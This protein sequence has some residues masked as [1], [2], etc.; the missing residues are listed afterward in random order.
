MF[1]E[2]A[3]H[4]PFARRGEEQYKRITT[5]II[6]SFFHEQINIRIE[7]FLDTAQTSSLRAY[8][9]LIT[10]LANL[11][12]M[13]DPETLARIM[14]A[15]TAQQMGVADQLASLVS[16]CAYVMNFPAVADSREEVTPMCIVSSTIQ[17]MLQL[18]EQ[19]EKMPTRNYNAT[20]LFR[21]IYRFVSLRTLPLAHPTSILVRRGLYFLTSNRLYDQLTEEDLLA[22]VYYNQDEQENLISLL[23][24]FLEV[25]VDGLNV[26]ELAATIKNIFERCAPHIIEPLLLPSGMVGAMVERM[27]S[28][29]YNRS[30]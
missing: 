5:K 11:I 19:M 4:Y 28:C 24:Y 9:Y 20:P 25:E 26:Y 18:E 3:T 14:A 27:L 22:M 8:D 12:K 21:E 29:D 30:E 17:L 10:A 2:A 6:K 7:L 16:R 13:G 15:K 23:A 1:L